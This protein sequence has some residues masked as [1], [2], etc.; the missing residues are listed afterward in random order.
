MAID[1]EVY[2]RI[3]VGWWDESNPLNLLQGSLTPPARYDYFRDVLLARGYRTLD[4]LRA[5]DIGSGGGAS[6]PNDSREPAA[7]SSASIPRRS[8]SKRHTGT[9]APPA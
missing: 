7:P 2:D 8:R 3:G 4:G 9:P 6:S 1:N 5:L